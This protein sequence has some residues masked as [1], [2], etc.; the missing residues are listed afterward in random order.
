M[1]SFVLS[2]LLALA[3]A[4]ALADSDPSAAGPVTE[5]RL[6]TTPAPPAPVDPS[7]VRAVERFLAARQSAGVLRAAGKAASLAAPAPK[8]A[9]AEALVGPAGTRLV[10]FDF[11]NASIEPSGRGRFDVSVYLLF[12]DGAGQIV[13]SRNE[14]LT[15]AG[16]AGSWSCVT[17]TTATAMTWDSG[18]VQDDAASQG[19]SE[20]FAKARSHLKAWSV[21]PRPL[22]YS[23]ADVSKGADGRVVVSCLRFSA[24][25]G[26]RGFDVRENP[27]VLTR[28]RG[29]LR[30]ESH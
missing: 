28:D 7:R 16:V 1:R 15:F 25:S 23:L 13:E 4:P 9:T 10:A 12:A 3:A 19:L 8:G 2:L 29:D 18:T 5:I 6:G 22:A 21:A 30:I 26:R 14:R 27:V 20:E 11:K 24:D 17:R